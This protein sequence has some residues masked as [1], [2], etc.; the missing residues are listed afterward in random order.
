[1]GYLLFIMSNDLSLG[2]FGVFGVRSYCEGC[3]VKK[4]NAKGAK[5]AKEPDIEECGVSF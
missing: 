1:M 3:G 4:I 2:K 5:G